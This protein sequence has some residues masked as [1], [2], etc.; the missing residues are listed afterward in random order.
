[1]KPVDT[2]Y[3]IDATEAGN[4]MRYLRKTSD[5]HQANMAFKLLPLEG[6]IG[7][8]ITALRNVVAGEEYVALLDRKVEDVQQVKDLPQV[9][10]QTVD[11]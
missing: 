7:V 4:D 5:P 8:F 2:D 11:H 1:L 9:S 3:Y 10:K 6:R